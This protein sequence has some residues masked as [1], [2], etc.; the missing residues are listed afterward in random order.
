[1]LAVTNNRSMLRRN[2]SPILV[3]MMEAIRSS[4]IPTPTRAT[5][6]NIQEGGFPQDAFVCDKHWKADPGYGTEVS[7]LKCSA[8]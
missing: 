8:V 3:T 1:M 7:V 2:N 5:R 6:R 4:E